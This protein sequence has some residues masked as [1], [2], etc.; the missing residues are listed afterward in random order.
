MRLC[1]HTHTHAVP[2]TFDVEYAR[3]HTTHPFEI[4]YNDEF[5]HIIKCSFHTPSIP[6]KYYAIQMGSEP[7]KLTILFFFLFFQVNFRIEIGLNCVPFANFPRKSNSRQ[8]AQFQITPF[9]RMIS[10]PRMLRQNWKWQPK[11]PVYSHPHSSRERSW[12]FVWWKL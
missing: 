11:N 12:L 1:A 9:T 2:S 7:P 5:S 6:R 8:R 3:T 10:S 4:W